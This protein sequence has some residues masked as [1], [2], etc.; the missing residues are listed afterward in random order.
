M[1]F[2]L[3]LALAGLLL[4]VVACLG[5]SGSG[6]VSEAL[7]PNTESVTV[8]TTVDESRSASARIGPEGGTLTAS[9]AD[10]SQFTLDIPAEALEAV[11]PSKCPTSTGR[12]PLQGPTISSAVSPT[13]S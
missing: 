7:D 6:D 9:G 1:R 11:E 5:G 12:W 8:T 4:G 10:G 3:I 13:S 2:R